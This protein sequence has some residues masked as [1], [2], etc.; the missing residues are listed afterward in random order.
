M[1]PPLAPVSASASQEPEECCSSQGRRDAAITPH[2][3]GG[4]IAPKTMHERTVRQMNHFEGYNKTWVDTDTDTRNIPDLSPD[5]HHS[6]VVPSSGGP[7]R[8]HE[9]PSVRRPAHLIGQ[10][11]C[12]K[13]ANP[14]AR[15]RAPQRENT[16]K[17]ID[18]S[19]ARTCVRGAHRGTVSRRTA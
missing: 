7:A 19:R 3:P 6:S 2:E 12:L 14:H 16:V 15:T 18:R 5:T 1:V 9:R 13:R 10:A 17:A 4:R 8:T 11:H